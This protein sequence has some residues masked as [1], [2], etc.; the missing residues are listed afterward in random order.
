MQTPIRCHSCGKLGHKAQGRKCRRRKAEVRNETKP[1]HSNSRSAIT[2]FKCGNVGH[3]ASVCTKG[4]A[5]TNRRNERRVDMCAVFQPNGTAIQFCERFQFSLLK[6]TFSEKLAGKR[7]H[8]CQKQ[9]AIL[10]TV[11]VS[12]FNFEILFHII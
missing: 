5:T 2:C 3:L 6:E 1:V 4:A 10:S 9:L 12:K 11:Q 7:C 8:K